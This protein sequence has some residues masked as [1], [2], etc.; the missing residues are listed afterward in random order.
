M[1]RDQ[2]YKMINSNHEIYYR[3]ELWLV[4]R[5]YLLRTLM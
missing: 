3:S 5:N 1:E 2:K 4:S